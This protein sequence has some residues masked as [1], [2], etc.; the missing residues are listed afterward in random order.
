[1]KGLLIVFVI[2]VAIGILLIGYNKE[3]QQPQKPAPVTTERDLP[4]K[5]I[6]KDL[7]IE[8]IEKDLSRKLK[9]IEKENLK[10]YLSP[11]Q[12]RVWLRNNYFEFHRTEDGSGYTITNNYY[13][14]SPPIIRKGD[15]I[16][17]GKEGLLVIG[18]PKGF[19]ATIDRE[20]QL[21]V[22]PDNH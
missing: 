9:E 17:V 16:I 11:A 18:G 8:N 7:S 19:S 2:F 10:D 12:S 6:E 15:K 4:I 14:P 21:R 3:Q 20:G 1:M 13:D 22:R 5:E